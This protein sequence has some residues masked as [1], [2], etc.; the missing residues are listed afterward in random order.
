MRI[1]VLQK[2]RWEIESRFHHH[3][4]FRKSLPALV[5][6]PEMLLK[7][8]ELWKMALIKKAMVTY[9]KIGGVYITA[10]KVLC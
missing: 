7:S 2:L 10:G 9:L 3:R 6:S 8:A 1:R 4:R 5:L